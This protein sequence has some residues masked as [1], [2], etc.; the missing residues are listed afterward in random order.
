M[1][2]MQDFNFASAGITRA[3]RSIIIL[4][5]TFV[6]ILSDGP[7]TTGGLIRQTYIK[8]IYGAAKGY[9][10]RRRILFPTTRLC[11]PLPQRPKAASTCGW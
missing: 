4:K 11:L 3:K 10:C 5:A 9:I 7:D 2:V 6:Q 8:A 1:R